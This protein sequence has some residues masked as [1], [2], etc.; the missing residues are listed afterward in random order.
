M[1]K[2]KKRK[3][4]PRNPWPY[5]ANNKNLE[6]PHWANACICGWHTHGHKTEEEAQA[7]LDKHLEENK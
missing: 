7:E 6:V 2:K 3:C 5:P 4:D 1:A